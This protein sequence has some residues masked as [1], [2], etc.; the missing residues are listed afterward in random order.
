MNDVERKPRKKCL[1]CSRYF[2]EDQKNSYYNRLCDKHGVT[3]SFYF[4]SE[5]E[6]KEEKRYGKKNNVYQ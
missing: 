4:M 3:E 1:K 5:L 6:K 2:T